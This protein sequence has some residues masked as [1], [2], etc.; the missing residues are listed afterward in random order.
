MRDRD[1]D[2]ERRTACPLRLFSFSFFSPRF[3]VYSQGAI[4]SFGF[5]YLIQSLPRVFHK[6]ASIQL[7]HFQLT[8]P[9]PTRFP[10]PPRF[11]PLPI[12]NPCPTPHLPFLSRFHSTLPPYPLSPPLYSFTR[13][14]IQAAGKLFMDAAVQLKLEPLSA[15][16]RNML[17]Q[18]RFFTVRSLF[19]TCSAVCQ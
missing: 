19:H 7:P 16:A 1:G 15:D 18:V 9:S 8:F 12:P 17:V 3:L 5:P 13:R 6:S 10:S 11:A 4:S 14:Q 2:Q